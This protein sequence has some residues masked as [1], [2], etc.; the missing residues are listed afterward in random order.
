MQ[1]LYIFGKKRRKEIVLVGST[2]Y[3]CFNSSPILAKL[4]TVNKQKKF[5]F[6][7]NKESEGSKRILLLSFVLALK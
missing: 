2:L 3:C 5:Y 1:L 6:S 7:E 4:I